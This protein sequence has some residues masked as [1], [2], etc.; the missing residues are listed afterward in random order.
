MDHKKINDLLYTADAHNKQLT[1]DCVIILGSRSCDYRVQT[2]LKVKANF[3]ICS[4][5]NYT[6]YRDSDDNPILEADFLK[7]H[8]LEAGIEESRIIVESN[9]HYTYQNLVNCKKYIADDMTIGV[10]TAGFHAERVR[11]ILDEVGYSAKIIPAYGPNTSP[12]NWFLN[13]TG[14]AVIR[15]ELKKV[16]PELV[17]EL[18]R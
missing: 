8:L 10:V 7:S 17:K 3:Y 1:Y 5:G 13:D 15:E 4:G 9:S 14:I 11:R 12:E 2:A 18:L 6:I 16:Y